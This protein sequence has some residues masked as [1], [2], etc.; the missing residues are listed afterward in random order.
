MLV[1]SRGKKGELFSGCRRSSVED[2]DITQPGDI[3]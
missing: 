1:L 3:P 2:K